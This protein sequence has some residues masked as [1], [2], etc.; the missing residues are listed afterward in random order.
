MNPEEAQ[1]QELLGKIR[2]LPPKGRA[3]VVKF[4]RE[5]NA[6][7]GDREAVQGM[8]QLAETAF[9]RVWDNPADAAYD[10]V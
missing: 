3:E 6:G 7:A 10:G 8:K 5:L 4:V 2:E 1:V 9:S